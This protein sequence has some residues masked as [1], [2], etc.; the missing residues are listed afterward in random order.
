MPSFALA[1][2]YLLTVRTARATPTAEAV[3]TIVA[4]LKMS[5]IEQLLLTAPA[6]F[7][8]TSNCL[9]ATTTTV[10]EE[11]GSLTGESTVTTR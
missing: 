8:F 4:N 3:I 2:K 10:E 9:V 1:Y 11:T 7:A 5:S 6:G